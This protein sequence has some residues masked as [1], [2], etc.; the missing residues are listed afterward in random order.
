MQLRTFLVHQPSALSSF[1]WLST[2]CESC[3]DS[4]DIIQECL[5]R[6][7]SIVQ[8]ELCVS[9]IVDCINL[10]YEHDAFS[11]ENFHDKGCWALQT[12]PCG[13]CV[14]EMQ[15]FLNCGYAKAFGCELHCGTDPT[16]AMSVEHTYIQ[17][18]CNV[19]TVDLLNCFTTLNEYNAAEC[20]KC[21]AMSILPPTA[22]CDELNA[23]ICPA[24]TACPCEA[25][26]F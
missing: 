25:C 5:A 9:C 11:C 4:R 16:P 8:L 18:D 20:E 21:V 26:A 6:E 10:G 2:L 23:G 1:M 15:H 19:G 3:K 12:C 14:D 13:S 17:Q 22:T 24:I 7:L